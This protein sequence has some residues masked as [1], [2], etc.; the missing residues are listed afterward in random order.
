MFHYQCNHNCCVKMIWQLD[1]H[2]LQDPLPK[3]S[4]EYVI[5][6]DNSIFVLLDL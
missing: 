4:Y 3:T 2:F 6:P 1:I 5:L